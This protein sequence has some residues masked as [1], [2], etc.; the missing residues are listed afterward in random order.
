M[1]PKLRP[2]KSL[3]L[4]CIK[5]SRGLFADKGCSAKLSEFDAKTS[6]QVAS[7]AVDLAVSAL[8]SRACQL[9]TVAGV[10]HWM[11]LEN[12]YAGYFGT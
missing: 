5:R 11:N 1:Q 3:P 6:K 9:V 2:I 7:E 4:I 10:G 12:S 8:D